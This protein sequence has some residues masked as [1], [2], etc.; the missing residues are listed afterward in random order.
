M[1][2]PSE[3]ENDLATHVDR[4]WLWSSFR[5]AKYGR[6]STRHVNSESRYPHSSLGR[7]QQEFHGPF[8][9]SSC[10]EGRTGQDLRVG[11]PSRPASPGVAVKEPKVY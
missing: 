2:I 9:R 5:L 7:G 4:T 11:P 1:W 6:R 3:T 10:Y 8:N